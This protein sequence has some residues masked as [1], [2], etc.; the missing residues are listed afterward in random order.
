M[1]RYFMTIPEAV[2]LVLRTSTL[3]EGG[4]IFVLDMGEPVSL[5]EMAADLVRLSGRIQTLV[6][7]F[8]AT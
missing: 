1:T 8:I 4:E 7:R 3:A 5:A 2:R 6:V